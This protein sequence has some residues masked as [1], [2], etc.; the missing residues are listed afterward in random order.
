MKNKLMAALGFLLMA[1]CSGTWETSY[2]KAIAPNVAQSWR[3]ANV[4]VA[5]PADLTTTEDN[6]YAPN[7][8]IVWHGEPFGDR[9]AQV[10]AIVQNG[11]AL[12]AR[13]LRG[14][15]RVNFEVVLLEFH[16]LTPQARSNA[17]SAVHN[18]SY[19][20]QVVDARTGEPLT[21]PELVRADLPAHTGAAA[22]DAIQRG[23]TQKVRITNHLQGVTA[24]WLGLGAD[25]RR[26]FSSAG[27]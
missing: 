27:R 25:L 16:A 24:G 22:F 14:R 10:A 26:S 3:V 15:Q 18:I 21:E 20:I 2:E 12:G 5:L 19:T 17:P 13:G 6:S 4:T 1:A 23:D 9:K 11:I 7:A 8:D